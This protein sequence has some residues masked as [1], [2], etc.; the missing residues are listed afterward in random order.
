MFNLVHSW[1]SKGSVILWGM[2]AACSGL[3]AQAYTLQGV[4]RIDDQVFAT[5]RSP[6][7]TTKVLPVG[8]TENRLIYAS[9][10]RP[11]SREAVVFAEGQKHV[12]RLEKPTEIGMSFVDREP[13]VERKPRSLPRSANNAL[14]PQIQ[15]EPTVGGIVV[16]KASDEPLTQQRPGGRRA[17]PSRTG[18]TL[19]VGET[20]DV[21]E[22]LLARPATVQPPRPS[23]LPLNSTALT[24]KEKVINS[25]NNTV[26]QRQAESL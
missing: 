11:N 23:M 6:S 4:T 1:I 13:V 5:V 14:V 20:N 18:G 10:W 17:L 19:V 25:E 16:G 9:E 7:G 3:L 2:T 26:G 22:Q 8:E 15:T 12:L 21:R 24:K